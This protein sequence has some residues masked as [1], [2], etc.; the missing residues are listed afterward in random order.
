M[1]PWIWPAD[2]PFSI[3]TLPYGVFR[4]SAT[5]RRASE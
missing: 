5:N 1:I 2:S 3:H 4:P